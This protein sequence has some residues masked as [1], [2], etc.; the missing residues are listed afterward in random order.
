MHDPIRTAGLNAEQAKRFTNSFILS[1]IT[2]IILLGV[3]IILMALMSVFYSC[4]CKIDNI[5]DNVLPYNISAAYR[6]RSFFMYGYFIRVYQFTLIRTTVSFIII[7]MNETNQCKPIDKVFSWIFL[8]VWNM[9]VPLALFV[10]L[11]LNYKQLMSHEYVISYGALYLNYRGIVKDG[12]ALL[13]QMR[14][15]LYAAVVI[16][17]NNFSGF[18]QALMI[19]LNLLFSIFIA[20]MGIYLKVVKVAFEAGTEFLLFAYLFLNYVAP[21]FI[22]LYVNQSTADLI[23]LIIWLMI[24]CFRTVKILYDTVMR[25][26]SLI[27]IKLPLTEEANLPSEHHEVAKEDEK[28]DILN[29]NKDKTKVDDV[30]K[31]NLNLKGEGDEEEE[32][33]E[34]E[35]E[36]DDE[37]NNNEKTHSKIEI[38]EQMSKKITKKVTKKI[39][40]K[41]SRQMSKQITKKVTN[42]MIELTEHKSIQATEK[43]KSDKGK[44]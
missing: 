1:N 10:K 32:D 20:V 15:F 23:S 7:I 28:I 34:S 38:T 37:E 6:A 11:R 41:M 26:K 42:Q 14:F 29:E 30:D 24:V 8:I 43:N 16:G 13:N 35:Y 21:Y 44:K 9:G 25:I 3:G 27:Q 40:K 31:S 4:C 12:Y 19:V 39:T 5:P 36:D 17:G 22:P 2:F 33:E 18:Q